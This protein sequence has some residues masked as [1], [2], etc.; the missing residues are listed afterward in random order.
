MYYNA[1][2][3]QAAPHMGLFVF[4]LLILGTRKRVKV[5][6]YAHL[7]LCKIFFKL[8]SYI[9]FD[10]PFI[11]SYC[12][13]HIVFAIF[14]LYLFSMYHIFLFF[15]ILVRKLYDIDTCILNVL[16]S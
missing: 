1:L 3:F 6:F 8:I 12:I 2:L 11:S 10:Y 4:C 16:C 5:F 7:V 15:D 13:A 14:P 9:F